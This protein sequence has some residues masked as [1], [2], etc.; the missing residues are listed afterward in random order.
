M[1]DLPRIGLRDT[2]NNRAL[3]PEGT[4]VSLAGTMCV[5]T[6]GDQAELVVIPTHPDVFK[7]AI[8]GKQENDRA[9]LG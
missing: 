4:V 5:V 8:T 9:D 3:A 6:W 1:S 7:N 2:A